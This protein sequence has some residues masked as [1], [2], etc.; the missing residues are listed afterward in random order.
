[1][2]RWS[3]ENGVMAGRVMAEDDFGTWRD[4][5]AEELGADGDA[6]VG[7]DFDVGALT[8]HK[9]PPRALGDWTQNGTFLF[10][11]EVPGLLGLHFEFPVD[12]VLVAMEAQ[13]MDMGIGLVEVGDLFTGKVSR[14]TILPEEVSALNFAFGLR[15]GSV[16]KGD[17]VEVKGTAQLGESLWYG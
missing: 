17:A 9:R 12:F 2:D 15:S 7:A 1:L 5:D 13:L 3:G 10:E 8:P 6:A 4:M 14:E 16:A 11:G